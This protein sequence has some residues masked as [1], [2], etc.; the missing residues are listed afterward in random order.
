MIKNIIF[1]LGGVLIDWDPKNVFRK[2]FTDSNQVD[3]FI[4]YICTMEWNVQ[5]DA[6]RSLENATKVL[7]LKHPEWHNTIAKYYG[8][9]E[10]MLN[11]PIHETVKIFKTIKDANK[12][13]IYALTNW[14]AE[15]FPI[16]IERYDFLKWF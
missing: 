11:G 10:T 7:Q 9:W 14:S 8:E 4:E 5:Q 6:G 2:V 15:T 16:A 3:L 1:D 13:K 12:Y